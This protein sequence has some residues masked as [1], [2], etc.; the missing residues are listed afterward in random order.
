MQVPQDEQPY[1]LQ[2]PEEGKPGTG[3]EEDE[4]VGVGDGVAEICETQGPVLT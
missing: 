1:S 4:G 3:E 2:V